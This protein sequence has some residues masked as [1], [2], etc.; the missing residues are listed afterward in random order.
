MLANFL[1][2][3]ILIMVKKILSVKTKYGSFQC[4]FE[5]EKDMGGYAVEARNVSG[6]ISWGRTLAEA[7]RMITEAI[8]GAIEAK[9]IAQ[10]E[11]KG[12]IQVKSNRH[13]MLSA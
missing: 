10:A 11:K 13:S 8:E 9:V 4:S 2:V 5:P 6:A 1:Y 7:K 3:K 12:I